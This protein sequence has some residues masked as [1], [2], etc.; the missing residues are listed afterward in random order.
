VDLVRPEREQSRL[1]CR[2][3]RATVGSLPADA[4]HTK[5]KWLERH[6]GAADVDLYVGVSEERRRARISYEPLAVLKNDDLP[7]GG[8]D[9]VRSPGADSM[10]P[11]SSERSN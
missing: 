1:H 6:L 5:V 4:A 11:G 3:Q 9:L 8:A 7:L 10:P 2:R